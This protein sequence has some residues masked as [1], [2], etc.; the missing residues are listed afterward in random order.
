MSRMHARK[1][2]RSR[3]RRPFLKESPDWVPLTATEIEETVVTLRNDGLSMAMIGLRMRDQY[4]VPDIKLATDS[5]VKD[6][7][8]KN[9][10]GTRLPE[11][12][13]A[14]MRR[15]LQI[16]EHLNKNTR[17]LHNKRGLALVEAKIRRLE[18]YYSSHG[19]LPA[20]WKYTLD[21]AKLEV[22]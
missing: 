4:G 20:G 5:S 8:L 10:L 16:K 9:D 15:A 17:D 6:I 7:L 3:S 11:D 1:K 14:L 13:S 18:R 22:E 19:R 2:G 12:M 21:R